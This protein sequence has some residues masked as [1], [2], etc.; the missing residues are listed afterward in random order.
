MGRISCEARNSVHF[1]QRDRVLPWA[2]TD[3]AQVAAAE[4]EFDQRTADHHVWTN[5]PPVQR[6]S[7]VGD[8]AITPDPSHQIQ[9][10]GGIADFW[11]L[12]DGR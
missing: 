11:Y 10:F 3:P 8:K 4:M 2:A 7:E 12:D 6:R 1:K 9:A 5:T